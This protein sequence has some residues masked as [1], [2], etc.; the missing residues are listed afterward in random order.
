MLNSGKGVGAADPV[1]HGEPDDGQ[2]P[3]LAGLETLPEDFVVQVDALLKRELVAW[4]VGRL[5]RRARTC[6]PRARRH[7]VAMPGQ[8]VQR[9]MM[10]IVGLGD[11]RNTREFLR[12]LDELCHHS[13]A[14]QEIFVR[15]H[16]ER[17]APE[18]VERVFEARKLGPH[19]TSRSCGSTCEPGS[20]RPYDSG[21]VF[22]TWPPELRRSHA[23]LQVREARAYIR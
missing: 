6:R 22:G 3:A 17:R 19:Y 13:I 10:Q 23:H 11:R 12:R 5:A 9:V 15:R 8:H 14:A 16:L 1:A 7:D 2:R 20:I 4:P 18:S 21:A